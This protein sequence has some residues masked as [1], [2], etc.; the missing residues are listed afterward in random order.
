M[1]LLQMYYKVLW[2]KKLWVLA[3]AGYSMLLWA[4]LF[5]NRPVQNVLHI[6]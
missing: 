1:T 6:L 3:A 4:V 2:C 5:V